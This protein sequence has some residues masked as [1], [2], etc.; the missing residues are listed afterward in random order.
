MLYTIVP[1]EEVM[2]VPQDA[3]QVSYIEARV[4]GR[5]VVLG[6]RPGAAPRIERLI[7]LDPFD[8]LDERW[9]PGTSVADVTLF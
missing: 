3:S 5:L 9:Q 2:A 6:I 8:Y 1:I 4:A 7:S